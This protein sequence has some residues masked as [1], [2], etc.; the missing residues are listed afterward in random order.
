MAAAIGL[1]IPLIGCWIK[2][3]RA[4]GEGGKL[5]H[6]EDKLFAIYAGP[7]LASPIGSVCLILC[8]VRIMFG[9]LMSK[10][11]A[12][13]ENKLPHRKLNDQWQSIFAPSYQFA[14]L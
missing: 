7:Y 2:F 14:R 9:G 4:P 3:D 6:E 13:G 10:P 11:E 5:D 12:E 1:L 8:T